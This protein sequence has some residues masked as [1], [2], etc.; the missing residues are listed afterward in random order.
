VTFDG[1][2]ASTTFVSATQLTAITPPHTMGAVDV[3]V[4]TMTAPKQFTYEYDAPANVAATAT[5]T[6]TVSLT[7]SA[8]P[9]ATRYEVSRLNSAIGPTWTAIGIVTG[10]AHSDSGLAVE[11]TYLY[12]VRAGDATSFSSKEGRDAVTMMSDEYATVTIGSPIL[13]A[14][15]T[16][17]RTR[18]NSVRSLAGLTLLAYTDPTPTII[19]AVH[20]TELRTRLTDA[21]TALA[22]ATPAFTDAELA[23]GIAVKA[24]HWNELLELMR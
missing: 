21:R 20:I 4:G 8:V 7:W 12:R 15:L 17:L 10:T 19:R 3:V 23:A 18:V 2:A 6:T 14:E 13:A 11:N 22:L 24:A 5:S 9:G 1:I 16:T